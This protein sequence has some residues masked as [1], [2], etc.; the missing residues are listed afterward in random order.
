MQTPEQQ[1]ND[2]GASIDYWQVIKNRYGV[3]LL[4]FLL[5]F[6]TAAVITSVMPRK[7]QSTSVVQVHPS[8]LALDPFGRGDQANAGALMTR[9]YMENEFE[10]IVAPETLVHAASQIDLATRWEME[11]DDVV[12]VLAGI[13]ETNPRRGTDFIEI[14]VRH[15]NQEDAKDIA[16]AIADAYINRRKDSELKRAK[17]A[18]ETL[19]DELQKQADLVQDRRKALTVLIQQYGIP[20]FDGRGGSPVG[21][22]EEA[23][24]RKAQEKL[25]SIGSMCRKLVA[26]RRKVWGQIT[27]RCRRL[28]AL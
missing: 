22:T 20:Y 2:A 16:E 10:T 24:Y 25:L 21:I 12:D 17:D 28:R 18:L 26:F 13:V 15:A 3:I 9:N 7:Y 11:S 27:L 1:I 8:M 6:L 14:E 5:V 19:D 23:L 4:T